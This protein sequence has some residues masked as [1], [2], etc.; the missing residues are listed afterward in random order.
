MGWLASLFNGNNL[1]A[2]P[3]VHDIDRYECGSRHSRNQPTIVLIPV[4]VEGGGAGQN[5]MAAGYP[6][7]VLMHNAGCSTYASQHP[8]MTCR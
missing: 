7:T 5:N 2:F 3:E 8:I 1:V 4:D 6:V